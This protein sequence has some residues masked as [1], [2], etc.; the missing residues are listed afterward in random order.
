MAPRGP[1]KVQIPGNI[2]VIDMIPESFT[3]E[4]VPWEEAISLSRMLAEHI[5]GR[6]TPDLVIAI[7]RGG[8]VPA[9]V[10][11]DSLM[12]TTLTSI[13]VEHWGEAAECYREARVRYPLSISVEGQDLL[14]IDDVTDTGDTLEAALEYIHSQNPQSVKTGVLHHKT[15]SSFIPDYYAKVVEGWHWIVYPWALHEDMT[16]FLE[17]VL[18]QKPASIQGLQESLKNRYHMDPGIE[19]IAFAARELV[20]AGKAVDTER[21]IVRANHKGSG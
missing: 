17:K 16:A 15:N 7:G 12:I 13:R 20:N 11:C 18:S 4:L 14:V 9:R 6:C 2:Q 3:V 8:F 5:R 10:V 21:G 19:E 1:G